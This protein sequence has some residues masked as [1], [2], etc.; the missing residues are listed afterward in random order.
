MSSA[1]NRTLI[2]GSLLAALAVAAGVAGAAPPKREVRVF[3]LVSQE[4]PPFQAAVAGLKRALQTPELKPEIEVIPLRGDAEQAGA[5]V[6]RARQGQAQIIVTLGSLATQAAARE[7]REIPIVA[8]LILSADDLGKAPNATAVILEFSVETEFRWL[9]RLL[10][11]EKNVAVLYNAAENQVRVDA[12]V[13]AAKGLGLVLNARK[14]ESPKELPDALDAL[15]NHADVIWGLADQVVLTPQTAQPILLFSM[16]NR[17]PFVGLSENWVKAG[18][19]Y[20]L[21][22]DYEDIGAQCGELAVKV[23]QGAPPSGLAAVPPRKVVYS[24]NLRTARHMKLDIPPGVL[25]DARA[26][27]E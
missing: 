2:G 7:V 1:V 18:A 25:R 14:L 19:L 9:Q 5:A 22:R 4:A 10:P 8:G 27:I 3:V 11:G 21:D 17:I 23:L 26:V 16:R 20:A 12:A 6:Q 13:R 15:T 24:I